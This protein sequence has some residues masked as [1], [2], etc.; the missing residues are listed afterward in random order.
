MLRASKDA[1]TLFNSDF[2]QYGLLIHCPACS[3]KAESKPSTTSA[4]AW[5]VV[6]VHCG[7]N[8]SE[9]TLLGEQLWLRTA[10]GEHEVFAY[11]YEHLAFLKQHIAATLRERN[12]S[13]MYHNK[14]L[15][16][17]LPRWMTAAKNR[18]AVLKCIEKLEKK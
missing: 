10:F 4:R 9:K 1:Y 5:R 2:L 12:H 8:S 18:E 17:R 13:P 15:A 7:Y 16:S 14:S 11:N 3:K 6:C